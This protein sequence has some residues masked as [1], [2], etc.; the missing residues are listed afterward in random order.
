MCLEGKV[1]MSLIRP[2]LRVIIIARRVGTVEITPPL[3]M[4]RTPW[5]G[6]LPDRLNSFARI[7]SLKGGVTIS[8]SGMLD[9]AQGFLRFP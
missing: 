5:G 4:L 9:F 1:T 2:L 7:N 8:C 3:L 6:Q